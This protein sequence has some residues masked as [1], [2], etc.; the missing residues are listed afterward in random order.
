MEFAKRAFRGGVH[1]PEKKRTK[2]CPITDIKDISLVRIPMNMAIG[3]PC[4]PTVKAGDHVDIGQVIG[5]PSGIAVPIHASI[6][7]KVKAVKAEYMG[8]GDM[9]VLVDIEND[10]QY[11]V[12]D[13]VTPPVI[14]DQ[15]SFVAAV[16]ASGLVGLGG[17]GFPTHVKMMP[18]SD[19]KP[20][21]LLINAMECEPYI[22]SDDRQCIENTA[23]IIRGIAHVLKWQDIPKALIGIEN[24]KKESAQALK[25]EINAQGQSERMEVRIF[26]V[27]YP[28]GAEKTFIQAA[29]GRI[30]PAGGLPHD[31]NVTMMNVSTVNY[32]NMYLETGM[33]LV[34][35][36]LT[37]SGDCP[38]H[39]GNYRVPI[40]TRISEL[41]EKAG[42]TLREPRKVLMGGPMMG[43]AMSDY[44]TP[45]VKNNNAILLLDE[46]ADVPKEGPCINCGRCVDACP[47]GLV[48]NRLNKATKRKDFDRLDE[49]AVMNCIECGC[50]SYECPARIQLVQSIRTGKIFYHSALKKLQEKRE[51]AN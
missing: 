20:D 43:L 21:V 24:N 11:T 37:L 26:P 18:P 49:L 15:A 6:S 14:K 41:I 1:P 19:K 22:T 39:P 25:D 45:V 44:S 27:R 3:A 13:T 32:L 38:N 36:V 12:A 16:K 5:E 40:G 46:G 7:G 9:M 42:G 10:F 8:T 17:A 23:S 48:P 34:H 51:A 33:P 47:M 35:R 29:T 28:Q 31:V 30:V 50:C 2:D 4:K